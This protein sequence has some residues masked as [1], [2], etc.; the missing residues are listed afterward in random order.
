MVYYLGLGSNLGDRRA[1]LDVALYLLAQR[2]GSVVAVS[3]YIE[4]EPWG[5]T[6]PN[7]FLNAACAVETTFSPSQ[8][9]HLTQQIERDLGRVHKSVPTLVP[10]LASEDRDRANGQPLSQGCPSPATYADRTIDIDLLLCYDNQGQEVTV[11]TTELTIPHPL[12]DRRDFVRIPMEEVR[13]LLSLKI[14]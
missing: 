2:V 5:F 12:I 11:H 14:C 7:T 9:L 6:S 10:T 4:T 8:V 3:S 1:N 13:R